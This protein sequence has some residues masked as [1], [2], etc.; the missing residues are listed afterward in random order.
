MDQ[1]ADN[2]DIDVVYVVTPNG[3]HAERIPSS[4]ARAGRNMC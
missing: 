4:A 1:M 2:P 3:L